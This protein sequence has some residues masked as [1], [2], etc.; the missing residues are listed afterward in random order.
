MVG[1]LS[2]GASFDEAFQAGMKAGVV[3][4]VAAA[5]TLAG[6]FPAPWRVFFGYRQND[7]KNRQYR[8]TERFECNGH[9]GER[10]K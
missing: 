6:I 5:Q 1:Q 8:R 9:A 3:S 2:A 7:R 10:G 4:A